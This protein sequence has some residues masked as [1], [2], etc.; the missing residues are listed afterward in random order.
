MKESAKLV[1]LDFIILMIMVFLYGLFSF[2]HLGSFDNPNTFVTKGE[3][4]F[5]LENPTNIYKMRYFTGHDM[6]SIKVSYSKDGENYI[7]L[8]EITN[9]YV[10]SWNDFEIN[11]NIQSIKLELSEKATLGEFS[12][13]NTRGEKVSLLSSNQDGQKLIDEQ[14]VVPEEIS[15]MNSTYFDEV[16]FARTA[17]EYANNL[18]AY[19]W[20]HPPLGKLIMAIPI[21]IFK[22]APFYYRLMG[23]IAGILMIPVLYIFAKRMFKKTKYATLAALFLCF[24]GFH[25]AQTRMATVDSFL[26]LFILLAFLFMYQYITLDKNVSLFQKLKQLF[27]S[28]L[29]M[30]LSMSVKWTGCFAAIGLAI[31]FFIHFFHTYKTR[32]DWKR[33]GNNIIIYCLLFFVI[34]PITI[35]IT[36][37]ICFPNMYYFQTRNTTEIGVIM[38]NMFQYHSK[39]QDPHPFYSSWYTW[40]FM[41]KPVWYY[42][43]YKGDLKGTISGFGNPIVWWLGILGVIYMF[44]KS[45]RKDKNAYFIVI[46][47]I[48]LLISYFKISR[49]MYLYHY[50]PALPFT[51]LA[52]TSLIMDITEKWKKNILYVGIII[53]VIFFFLYFFPVISGIW[54]DPE[55]IES[56]KWFDSWIF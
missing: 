21:K 49:G 36:C 16:Y 18:P 9:K 45:F 55:R 33:E 51:M 24:D 50:F 12:L 22:M 17:Y 38:K 30:G 8:G 41:L 5:S 47:Y 48:C 10:F 53:L 27:F 46:T 52:A 34:I 26:V 23:N 32:E 14:H 42:V 35:Y 43:G 2:Y 40:P 31:L 11:E 56:L 29:F 28:G 20:V 19:E 3:Y 6:D 15:Y 39:L 1:K 4:T 7:E 25:Y 13:Y 54:V 44:Y 37:Y